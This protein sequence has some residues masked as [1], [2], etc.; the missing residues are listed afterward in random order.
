MSPR[1]LYTVLDSFHYDV[2]LSAY[3][4]T[5]VGIELAT[6]VVKK[7]K[8]KDSANEVA[9]SERPTEAPISHQPMILGSEA[10]QRDAIN[11]DIDEGIDVSESSLR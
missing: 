10:S 7:K 4:E 6:D 1:L 2:S 3:V 11:D 8:A 5:Q 9:E